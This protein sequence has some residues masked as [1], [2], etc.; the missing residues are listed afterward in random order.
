MDAWDKSPDMTNL[1][2]VAE[3]LASSAACLAIECDFAITARNDIVA[4]AGSL[5]ESA[6]SRAGRVSCPVFASSPPI[7]RF[8]KGRW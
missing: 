7:L 3:T 8:L 6:C 5:M 4:R 2:V 1:Y